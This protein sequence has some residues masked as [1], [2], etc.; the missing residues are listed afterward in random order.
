MTLSHPDVSHGLGEEPPPPPLTQRLKA[1]L[2]VAG[3]AVFLVV[4]PLFIRDS[5]YFMSIAIL[6]LVFACYAVAFN[7]IFGSTAQLFLC[8]G[9]L[10]GMSAYTVMILGNDYAVPLW[11]SL[12]IG[13]GLAAGFGALFSWVAVR[14]H[15]DIIFIGIVTLAFSLVFI[16]V[17]LGLRN[18]TGGETGRLVD[19]GGG[20]ILRDR[21]LS[22][23]LFSVLLLAFLIVYRWIERSH[24]GWAFRALKDDE[25]AAEL[26]GVNVARYRILAG[27]IGGAM[28]GLAGGLYAAHEGFISPMTFDFAHVDVRVLIILAFG[29]IGSLLGPVVGAA[30][31]AVVDELL[32]PLGQLR[33][34]VYGTVLVLLFLGFRHGM[35][36]WAIDA[37]RRTMQRERAPKPEA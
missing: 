15:L 12:P 11:G 37:V 8:L 23:L 31:V 7:L 34:A 2:P 16:N 17:L 24:M 18:L 3:A 33:L 27:T 36:P 30:A 26:A 9:A 25:L 4:V 32:R 6:M 22:Y 21:T 14:R 35:I 10:S 1:Y 28:V 29:G 5:R 19:A 20:T 13:V